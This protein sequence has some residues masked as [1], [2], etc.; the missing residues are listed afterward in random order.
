[1][2]TPPPPTKIPL[3]DGVRADLQRARTNYG[4]A[5]G[6]SIVVGVGGPIAFGVSQLLNPLNNTIAQRI[7]IV[8]LTCL[9]IAMFGLIPLMLKVK[10]KVLRADLE[11]GYVEEFEAVVVEKFRARS[12][13]QV[14]IGPH[15]F[16]VDR[17]RYR[18]LSK[19][20]TVRVR[21]TPNARRVVALYGADGRAL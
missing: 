4:W 16:A 17:R 6:I 15:W 14:R 5:L 2:N 13:L 19:G 11:A 1:M 9:F 21:C 18:V 10:R 3:D 7:G 12:G 8:A 20:L